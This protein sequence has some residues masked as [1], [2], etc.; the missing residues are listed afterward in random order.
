LLKKKA[1]IQFRS[2]PNAHAYREFSLLRARF[3]Y[4]SK[5]CLRRYVERI[6]SSLI[7]NPADYWKF[8][9]NKRSLSAIP[10]IVSYKESTST[11]ERE[12]ANLFSM[13]FSSI[14]SD[15]HLNL[16]TSSLGIM[17]SDL[18]NN[19]NFTGKMFIKN[20]LTC[21]VTGL[22]DLMISG[23][24]LYQLKTVIAFSLWTL[25]KRSLEE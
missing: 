10:M 9:K 21:M 24:Y 1:H 19:V 23:E 22:L 6:E 11:N 13:Y 17:S 20:Y 2:S 4:E 18:P 16:D 14:F 12:T 8:V 25:F 3:K 15:N 7:S 5:K